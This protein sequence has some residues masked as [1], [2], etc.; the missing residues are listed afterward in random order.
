L[1]AAWFGHIQVLDKP[2]IEA[3]ICECY[4][5]LRKEYERLLP[6]VTNAELAE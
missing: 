2:A 3:R 5:V 6:P 1:I 4:E